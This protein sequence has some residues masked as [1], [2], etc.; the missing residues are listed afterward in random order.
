VR[1]D[2][3]VGVDEGFIV[4]GG[5]EDDE[6]ENGADSEVVVIVV[7]ILEPELP[8]KDVTAD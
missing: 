6:E 4:D 8:E 7:E 2:V 1:N 3:V 5:D